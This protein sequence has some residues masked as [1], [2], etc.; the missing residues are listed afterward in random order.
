MSEAGGQLLQP[1]VILMK[2]SLFCQQNLPENAGNSISEG[3]DFKKFPREHTPYPHTMRCAFG[4]P[5]AENFVSNSPPQPTRNLLLPPLVGA[6]TQGSKRHRH[7]RHCP[8]HSSGLW[9]PF[10]SHNAISLIFSTIEVT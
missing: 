10:P 8:C 9:A 4:A 6:L 7:S 5:C 1:C 3:H 2:I